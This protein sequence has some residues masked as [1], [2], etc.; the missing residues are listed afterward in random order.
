MNKS[1]VSQ[2]KRIKND[3]LKK[4][5][6][7]GE[8]FVDIFDEKMETLDALLKTDRKIAAGEIE[9]SELARRKQVRLRKKYREL[10]GSYD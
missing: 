9:K 3:A 4:Y 5:S 8:I 7:L 6:N 2:L 10:G 1:W